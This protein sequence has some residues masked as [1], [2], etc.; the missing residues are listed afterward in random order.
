MRFIAWLLINLL[1]RLRAESIDEGM[2]ESAQNY[3]LGSFPT[4]LETARQLAAQYAMLELYGLDA[5]YIDNYDAAIREVTVE[6][7]AP[8]V[9]AVYPADDGLVFVII[10]DAEM[11]RDTVARYGALSEISITDG[12]FT[13]PASEP[14]ST[15]ERATRP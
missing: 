15:P 5:G 11:I 12:S 7:I 4:R 3:V 14:A 13:A 2:L 1:Y 10:G 6:S 8:V 9:N